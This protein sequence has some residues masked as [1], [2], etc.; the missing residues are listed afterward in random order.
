MRRPLFRQ[1][2]SLR[3]YTGGMPRDGGPARLRLQ[4]AALD[5]YQERGYDQ[6]TA[7][8]IAARADVTERTFYRHFADK[9][10]VL[11]DGEK[12]LRDALTTALAGTPQALAPLPALLRSFRAVVPLLEGNRAF[13][14]PRQRVIDATPALRER[15][16]AKTAALAET[17]A[18]AL[19]DRGIPEPAASLASRVGVAAFDHAVTAWF[20]DPAPGL[21]PLLRDTF[22]ELSTLTESLGTT[23]EHGQSRAPEAL[24]SRSAGSIRARHSAPPAGDGTAKKTRSDDTSW[25]CPIRCSSAMAPPTPN[26]SVHSR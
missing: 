10:E 16:Q 24:L 4:Q 8:E 26:T 9:R 7:A 13:S 25:Y 12:V 20:Q 2:L 15:E 22:V 19:R 21:D 11:F 18:A 14:A 6:V 17:L 23:S 5:L 1:S 3:V